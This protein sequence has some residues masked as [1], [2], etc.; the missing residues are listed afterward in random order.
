MHKMYLTKISV[1]GI[2]LYKFKFICKF[3][4]YHYNLILVVT[5]HLIG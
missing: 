2:N 1:I 4:I 5:P 3:V